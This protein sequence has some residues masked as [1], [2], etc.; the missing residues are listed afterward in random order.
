MLLLWSRPKFCCLVMDETVENFVGK[1]ENVGYQHFLLSA[2][3]IFSSPVHNV[4][5]VS[6]CDRSLSGVC[7][8]IRP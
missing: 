4:L 7:S 6:Y 5:R 3:S 8:S 2:Q 1:G